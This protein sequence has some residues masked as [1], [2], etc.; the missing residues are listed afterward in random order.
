MFLSVSV[1]LPV[2][3]AWSVWPLWQAEE[4][5]RL[6]TQRLTKHI[7]GEQKCIHVREAEHIVGAAWDYFWIVFSS[8]H[9]LDNT[10]GRNTS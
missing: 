8:T 1:G 5:R 3:V 10:F 2:C 6:D 7:C 9:M 4:R